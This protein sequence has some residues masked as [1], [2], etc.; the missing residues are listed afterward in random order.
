M[1]RQKGFASIIIVVLIVILGIGGIGSIIYLQNQRT[2]SNNFIN[3]VS[4][5]PTKNVLSEWKTYSNSHFPFTFK[6]PSDLTED[7]PR[8][9]SDGEIEEVKDSTLVTTVL[10]S[11]T[12]PYRI[13]VI[14][15]WNKNGTKEDGEKFLDSFL[16]LNGTSM[17]VGGQRAVQTYADLFEV[18]VIHTYIL[19]K[20]DF[21]VITLSVHWNEEED[22]PMKEEYNELLN[23][24]LSTFNFN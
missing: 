11:S 24:I 5:T 17:T 16:E 2:Q 15:G 21:S 8:K 9:M 1:H 20:S 10:Y 13:A 19:N 14:S 3:L 12:K 23:Q 4:P 6:Y 7:G 22:K 18:K